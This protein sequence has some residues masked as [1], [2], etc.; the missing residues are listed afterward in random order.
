MLNINQYIQKTHIFILMLM[1]AWLISCSSSQQ[2]DPVLPEPEPTPNPELIAIGFGGKSGSWQ[3][4]A[5]TRAASNANTGLESL[6]QSF[7]IWGYKTTNSTPQTVMDGYIVKYIKNTS[8]STTS[9]TADWEYVGISNPNLSSPQSIK[10]WDYSAA[11]YR[12]FAYTPSETTAQA[13]TTNE[14]QTIFTFPFEY[15]ENTQATNVP[16]VSD[17]WYSDNH[18]TTEKYGKCVTLT[19]APLLAKVRFKFKYPDGTTEATIT[20]IKFRDNRFIGNEAAATTPLRGH[21]L[22]TYQQKGQPS[23]EIQSE[24]TARYIPTI[25]WDTS[26][27][28]GA[29][30]PLILTIPYEEEKDAVH[31]L[32][33]KTLYNKWYYVPPLDADKGGFEQGPYTITAN[34]NGNETSTTVPAAYMKWK[35]GYQYTYVFKITPANTSIDFTDLEVEQWLPGVNI[36]NEGSGTTDW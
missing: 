23:G 4:D 32:T 18:T 9:N 21:I 33:D 3:E 27:E 31:I 34:I 5:N 8:G 25:T 11:D 14:S 29:T 35:A 24:T 36:D 20:D 30:G 22:T 2:D 19:F 17:L 6:Y 28:E 15:S 1:A 12:F 7:R 10:Y 16:Y 26:T 13:S